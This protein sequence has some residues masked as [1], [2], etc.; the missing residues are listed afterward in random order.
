VLLNPCVAEARQHAAALAR[1]LSGVQ[2]E[3]STKDPVKQR[4]AATKWRQHNLAKMT[5][6]DR[7]DGGA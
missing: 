5:R 2:M 6:Y 7:G 3:R 4:A 1:V